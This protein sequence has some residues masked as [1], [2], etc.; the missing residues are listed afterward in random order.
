MLLSVF[1]FGFDEFLQDRH[2]PGTAHLGGVDEVEGQDRTREIGVRKALGATPF[3][4]IS[5]IVQESI[6]LT[7]IAGYIGMASGLA[8]VWGIEYF[9][10]ANEIEAEF[11]YNPEVDMGMV[12]IAFLIL[13]GS[14]FVSGL[15]PAL[16]AVRIHPVIAMKS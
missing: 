4:I 15:I 13:V 6:L 2:P 10:E 7:S 11:F 14:G 12:I 8:L 9:M 5:M 16:Q 1:H 3:S